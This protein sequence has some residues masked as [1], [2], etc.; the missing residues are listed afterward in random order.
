MACDPD[1]ILQMQQS[2]SDPAATAAMSKNAGLCLTIPVLS[3]HFD[4][5]AAIN[6]KALG[7]IGSISCRDS[8]HL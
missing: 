6:G 7:S 2:N 4:K 5:T 1:M 3:I 8:L